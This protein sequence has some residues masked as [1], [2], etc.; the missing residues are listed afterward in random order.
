M[1]KQVYAAKGKLRLIDIL[2]GIAKKIRDEEN[3]KQSGVQDEVHK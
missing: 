3:N 1:R 2:K